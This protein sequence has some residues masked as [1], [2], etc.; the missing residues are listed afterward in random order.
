ME[1]L[2]L[3]SVPAIATAVYWIVE[4]IKHCVG[5]NEKFKRFIPLLS[6][7]LGV[8]CGVIC[9]FAIPSIV[10]AANVVVAIVIGAASGLTATGTNQVIKQLR[11]DKTE[12]KDDAKGNN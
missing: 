7:G 9:Y 10:P 12:D 1:Y 8:V 4:L 5:E 2:E 6:A 3:I 11:I